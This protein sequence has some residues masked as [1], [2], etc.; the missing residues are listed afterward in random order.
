M[1]SLKL[2]LVALAVSSALAIDTDPSFRGE[3][4]RLKKSSKSSKKSKKN[5]KTK[6]QYFIK[7]TAS[8]NETDGCYSATYQDKKGNVLGDYLDCVTSPTTFGA[9]GELFFEIETQFTPYD[10][11][12]KKSP[13]A[14]KITCAVTVTPTDNL[15]APFVAVE[16]CKNKDGILSPDGLEGEVKFDALVDNTKFPELTFDLS[17][18]IK[19][20]GA[21]PDG[22]TDAP[23][24]EEEE[25]D[26][27]EEEEEEEPTRAPVEKDDD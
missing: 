25:D 22:E 21:I 2:L 19:Y 9:N 7:G 27:G 4:R 16:T 24:E 5:K 26:E 6:L 11:T 10:T 23:V 3:T 12:S 14:F 13:S 17:W 1:F 18:T 8:P 15:P 20:K